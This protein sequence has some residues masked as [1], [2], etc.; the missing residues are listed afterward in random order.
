[1]LWKGSSRATAWIRSLTTVS[2]GFF[3]VVCAFAPLS[4]LAQTAVRQDIGAS[5]VQ[6]IGA[7]AGLDTSTDIYAI[8]GKM[9]NVFFSFLGIL[10][11]FYFLYAG[12]LYM[13][14]NGA[15]EPVEK[16]KG[17]MKNAVIG[18]IIITSSFAISQFIL[19]WLA[20]G[21]GGGSGG[22]SQNAG[23]G[24]GR[25]TSMGFPG[26]AGALGAGVLEYHIPE[27][28]ARAV[29]RN[30]SIMISFKQP[31]DPASIIAGWT[32]TTSTT[33]H[34]VSADAV[35]IFQTGQEQA[36]TL[37]PQDLE[38]YLSFDKQSLVIRPKQSI[39]NAVR[40]SDYTVRLLGG[41]RALRLWV[42]EGTGPSIFGGIEGYLSSEG[43]YSWRF[44]VSTVIDNTP[45]R[46]VSVVPSANA[47]YAPNIVVQMHFDKALNPIS[48]SGLVRDGGGFQ[49]VEVSATPLQGTGSTRPSGLFTLSNHFRT[50]E[51]VTNV[52]CG[53]NSC[54]R[55][56]YCL[57]FSSTIGVRA[58]AAS[59]SQI[60]PQARIIQ[61]GGASIYDGIVDYVGNS[62]DGN[63]DGIAQGPGQDDYSWRFRTDARPN[64]T[65]PTIRAV[66]PAVRASNI[67]LDASVHADFDSLL[68]T[69]TLSSD[70]VRLR[71]NEPEELR[72]T[73]W[74]TVDMAPLRAD[75]G[76]AQSG[77][78]AT[79]SRT[80][81]GHRPFSPMQTVPDGTISPEY[82]PFVTS[83]VQNVYQNC[84][85][86]AS[87]A[88]C[89]GSPYCCD[90]RPSATACAFP[91][92]LQTLPP[93]P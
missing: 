52:S 83:D 40:N 67:A 56:V 1:M 70:T 54:G 5:S 31:I 12:Y 71:T 72:D 50:I 35:R 38:A 17:I 90:D 53:V 34:D 6:A 13:T 79:Q 42:P 43:G 55:Q 81:I 46:I 89:T 30:T 69:S 93:R 65:P 32:E 14:A 77:D 36:T 27:R 45:P 26:S 23:G 66:V 63:D 85:V 7:G 86:P 2:I 74:W 57:P 61:N 25:R 49:N 10:L 58:K 75:G 47:E 87:S 92:P 51:F 68:Q 41:A 64:L 39:G 80:R 16:A 91:G 18:L 8:I 73:F 59:L 76:L 62:F 22:A 44:E 3:A 20:D 84:F 37:R 15:P 48:A 9:L 4:V 19:N 60:P 11:L 28:D 24:G 33:A 78:R 88:R 21:G 82:A 29:P